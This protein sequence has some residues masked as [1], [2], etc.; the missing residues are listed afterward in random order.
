VRDIATREVVETDTELIGWSLAGNDDAFVEL[1]HRHAGAVSSYLVR[2]VGTTTAEDLLADVW[3][4]AFRSRAAYDRSRPSAR[5]W[6]FGIA[7]NVIHTFW[8]TRPD[9]DLMPDVINA[10]T[11]DPWAAVND[12]I[13]GL[14]VVREVLSGL[15]I[16]QREVLFLVVWEQLTVTDAAEVIGMPASTARSH[17]HRARSVLRKAPGVLALLAELNAAKETE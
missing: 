1:V 17:L 14:T 13:D 10:P 11:I 7:R 2:R 12:R 8:R 6:L 5:P 3:I 15:P 16:E 9:E 4:A